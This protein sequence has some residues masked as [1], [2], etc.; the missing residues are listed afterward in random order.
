[1]VCYIDDN[2]Q[3][4]S[5]IRKSLVV[6]YLLWHKILSEP[7]YVGDSSGYRKEEVWAHICKVLLEGNILE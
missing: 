6:D 7:V 5:M 2:G 4:V 1:M 3:E